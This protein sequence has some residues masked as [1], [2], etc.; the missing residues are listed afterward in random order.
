MLDLDS[1]DSEQIK[2]KL[3]QPVSDYAHLLLEGFRD[4]LGAKNPI[5]QNTLTDENIEGLVCLS[6]W[7]YLL[8]PTDQ[9][10]SSHQQDREAPERP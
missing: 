9:A 10:A 5:I 6:V 3:S 2:Q 1:N 8:G 7:K 4:N